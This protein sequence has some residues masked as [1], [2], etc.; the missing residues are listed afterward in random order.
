MSSLQYPDCYQGFV[1]PQRANIYPKIYL[2]ILS[3]LINSRN[4]MSTLQ[5]Q[6][7]LWWIILLRPWLQKKTLVI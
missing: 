2:P 6:A 3:F 1:L 4:G 5:I 7:L